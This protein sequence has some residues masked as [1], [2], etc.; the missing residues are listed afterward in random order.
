MKYSIYD[1]AKWTNGLAFKSVHFSKN[2][3][4]EPVIKIAELKNGL[5]EKTGYTTDLFDESIH[6]CKGDLL[7]S[8]SGSPETSIDI[9]ECPFASG[10]LNQH[11]F[12]VIPKE[13]IIRKKYFFYLMKYYKGTF[14]EIAKM[15]Q[16]TGLGHVTV[17][18]LKRLKVNIPPI[19]EQDRIIAT[20]VSFD[21]KYELN[22]NQNQILYELSEALL[23]NTFGDKLYGDST[24]SDYLLPKRGKPLLSKDA[25]DGKVPV[26]AGG[27]EPAAY[28]NK[29][30]TL[31][32]VIT[33][34][35]SG[36][37][38]GFVR[39]WG[40]KVWSSD[41]SYIDSSVTEN[42]YFWYVLLKSRQK[43]IYD[44]QTGSAQAHIYPRH[45]GEMSIG[46]IANDEISKYNNSVK[47]FFEKIAHNELENK[48]L[49][50]IRDAVLFKKISDIEKDPSNE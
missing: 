48:S 44:M 35:A 45:I 2:G 11:I 42:V 50:N 37:N 14:I 21:K 17:A 18:D 20:L 25:M 22:S 15:K 32:P 24:I 29:P 33:I 3:E 36:A 12:K 49:L 47:I 34:S 16:T 9:F 7:F 6:L 41:S 23:L 1:L 31:A 38:A 46:A 10:W 13:N 8:W 30:N 26:V 27:L 5:T 40:E 19:E 39:L 43:E 28:H 4:G